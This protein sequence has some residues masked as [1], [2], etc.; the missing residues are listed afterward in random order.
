MFEAQIKIRLNRYVKDII[1]HLL[2]GFLEIETLRLCGW[3][4]VTKFFLFHQT[5]EFLLRYLYAF[6]FC[7]QANSLALTLNISL[8][9]LSEAIANQLQQSK[10]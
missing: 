4:F 10:G 9:F 8:V 7:N 1:S 5:K 6:E 2:E 3:S